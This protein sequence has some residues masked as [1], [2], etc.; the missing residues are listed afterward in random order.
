M[1]ETLIKD[2]FLLVTLHCQHFWR[3]EWHPRIM[4][5][6]KIGS[7][8]VAV[9]VLFFARHDCKILLVVVHADNLFRS[10]SF[11]VSWYICTN[12]DNELYE[13]INYENDFKGNIQNILSTD[14]ARSNE[15][16]KW[17]YVLSFS[18]L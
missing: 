9:G 4:R 18:I 14:T 7:T 11:T 2:V 6:W 5:K 13:N 17:F 3:R 16:V 15:I 10:V 1:N 12:H 8:G